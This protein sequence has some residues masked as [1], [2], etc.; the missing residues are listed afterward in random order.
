MDEIPNGS[1]VIFQLFRK[2]QRFPNQTG[3]SFL[4]TSIQQSLSRLDG[5]CNP[6]ELRIGDKLATTVSAF[7]ILFAVMGAPILDH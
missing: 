2:G 6:L 1:N 5:I 3:H 7:I 4:T